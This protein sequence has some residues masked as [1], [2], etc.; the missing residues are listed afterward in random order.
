[1]KKVKTILALFVLASNIANS[2]TGIKISPDPQVAAKCPI[3]AQQYSVIPIG[4]TLPA[5]CTFTWTVTGGVVSNGQNLGKSVYVIWNDYTGKGTL[6]VTTSNCSSGSE[7]GNSASAQYTRLSVAGMPWPSPSAYPTSYN[8]PLCNPP[9]YV[10][11]MVDQL[12]VKNTGGIAEPPQI[13]VD[14]Y[15]W[16]IPAGWMEYATNKQGPTTIYTQ[17]RSIKLVPT[18]TTGGVVSVSG[19]VAA[20]CGGTLPSPN[21]TITLVRTPSVNLSG[22]PGFSS[23]RCGITNPLTFTVTSLPCATSYSWTK[24][25]GWTGT[26]TSNSITVTPN[27][28]NGGNIS[29]A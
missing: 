26:S 1:M 25:S 14:A 15:G 7:N 12:Y 28:Q 23:V 16:S 18:G 10:Q 9:A 19:T 20:T 3:I 24:P 11:L 8:V 27:G 5:G 17:T 6:T 4:S 21:K 2:A 22:A 29:V 13:A